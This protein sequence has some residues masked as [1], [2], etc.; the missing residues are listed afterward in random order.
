M[1]VHSSINKNAQIL[2]EFCD[3]AIASTLKDELTSMNK[4]A[5]YVFETCRAKINRNQFDNEVEKLTE[6][7]VH[8]EEKLEEE[9]PLEY[10][11][12]QVRLQLL[13]VSMLQQS[14]KV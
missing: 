14:F 7:L 1:D 5:S 3:K 2:I 11:A 10:E 12:I 6:W 9:M 4:L 13:E 8:V